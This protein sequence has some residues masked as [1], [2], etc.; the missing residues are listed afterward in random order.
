MIAEIEKWKEGWQGITL[1]LSNEEI[2][3]FISLLQQIRKDNEQHFHISSNWKGEPGV[4]DIEIYVK[5]EEQV[6]N[7]SFSSLAI[8]PGTEIK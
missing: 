1:G 4:G 5:G 8:E 3:E 7:M 6:N 2:D